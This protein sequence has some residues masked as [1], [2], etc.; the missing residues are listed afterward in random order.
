MNDYSVEITEKQG[1]CDNALLEKMLRNG[2]ITFKKLNELVDNVVEVY[3]YAVYKGTYNEKVNEYLLLDTDSGFIRTGSNL[4]RKTFNDYKDI[5][6]IFNIRAIQ[7]KKG[8]SYKP[9]PILVNSKN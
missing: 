3:G 2:D 6:H 8:I 5:I 1:T 9:E 4:F 7:C